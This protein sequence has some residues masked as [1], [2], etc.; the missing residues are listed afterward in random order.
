[1]LPVGV[2]AIHYV[3]LKY[4]PL[5]AIGWASMVADF[6]GLLVVVAS[7]GMGLGVLAHVRSNDRVQHPLMHET[8]WS[9]RALLA[10]GSLLVLAGFVHGAWYSWSDLYRLEG[11]E[12]RILSSM[13]SAAAERSPAATAAVNDYGL[14]QAEKAVKIAAHS[15]VIE[16]GI[17]AMLLALVQPYVFLSETWRRRWAVLL[18]AGGLILPVFVLQELKWGLVAG[19]IADFGGLLVVIALIG[20]LAGIV[21]YTGRVDGEARVV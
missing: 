8:S 2:F 7:A 17:L 14:L 6:G 13:I 20:M 15:H 12:S 3:G 11:R 18:L 1:M 4:S 9:A 5:S 16:F 19:G 21:R 10:G